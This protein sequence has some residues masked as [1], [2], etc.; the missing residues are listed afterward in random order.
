[1]VSVKRLLVDADAFVAVQNEKDSNHTRAIE[2]SEYLFSLKLQLIT[3]DPA[4]GEA[5]T[6]ISQKAGLQ[7]AVTFAEELLASPT[8]I[9]E[10][11]AALRRKA[12]D[13]FKEQTSKNTRFTDCINM[14]I[15]KEEGLQ[16]IFSFDEDYK[17]NGFLRIGIDLPLS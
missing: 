5:I 17:K 14:A 7:K 15:M 3:S 9:V 13:I 16:E 8:E 1:M 11:D 6:I 10:V 4:F 2:I 12:L